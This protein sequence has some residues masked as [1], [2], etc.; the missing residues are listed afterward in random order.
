MYSHPGDH[1]GLFIRCYI[2]CRNSVLFKKAFLRFCSHLSLCF[3]MWW[4]G[5][6][7]LPVSRTYLSPFHN[8]TCH[9]QC[10]CESA[11]SHLASKTAHGGWEKPPHS[12]AGQARLPLSSSCR[13]LSLDTGQRGCAL[14]PVCPHAAAPLSPS[15]APTGGPGSAGS[16]AQPRG[17]PRAGQCGQAASRWGSPAAS[18][19]RAERDPGQPSGPRDSQP[20]VWGLPRWKVIHVCETADPCVTVYHGAY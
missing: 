5:F 12:A 8:H 2:L 1:L 9:M 3:H 10:F 6:H 14:A 16:R 15:T 13:G 4:R 7:K 20:G 11:A 18:G 19:G 17:Q